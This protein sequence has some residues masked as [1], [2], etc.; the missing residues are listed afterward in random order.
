[1]CAVTAV[2]L[3]SL[4]YKAGME[5]IKVD[6]QAVRHWSLWKLL[7]RIF[8]DGWFSGGASV[9]PEPGVLT[10]R[11]V[12]NHGRGHRPG[13]DGYSGNHEPPVRVGRCAEG[14]AADQDVRARQRYVVLRVDH[15]A[16][17]GA[18]LGECERGGRRSRDKQQAQGGNVWAR[19]GIHC[20]GAGG[21]LTKATQRSGVAWRRAFTASARTGSNP[22]RI[23][24]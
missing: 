16:N 21:G 22:T 2:P 4:V 13:S 15:G 20:S 14:G 12:S 7:A 11:L 18:G 1:M 6:G 8:G 23:D 10:A 24:P 9:F 19:D 17:D 5:V 3:G